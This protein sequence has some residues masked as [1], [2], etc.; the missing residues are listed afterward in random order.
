MEWLCCRWDSKVAKDSTGAAFLDVDPWYDVCMASTCGSWLC[1][2]ATPP[3]DDSGTSC[4]SLLM[5]ATFPC[6]AL[7]VYGERRQLPSLEAPAGPGG[8]GAAAFYTRGKAQVSD[9]VTWCLVGWRR[10][11]SSDESKLSCQLSTLP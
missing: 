1:V 7:Q 10:M 5:A 11:V 4:P 8:E 2:A 9:H 3:L 6:H